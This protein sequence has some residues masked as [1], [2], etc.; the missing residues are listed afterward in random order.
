MSGFKHKKDVEIES[1][2]DGMTRQIM[3]YTEN[4]MLVRVYFEEGAVGYAHSHRHEQVSYVEAGV[5]EVMI[6]GEK[7]ILKAGDAFTVAPHLEHGAVCL[8]KGILIDTFS[9]MREDF[10]S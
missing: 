6:D 1:V 3:G 5:F 7:K 9:P 4:L 10:I 2:A 8:E